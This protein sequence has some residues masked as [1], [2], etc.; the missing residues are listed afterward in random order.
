MATAR[1]A[2]RRVSEA[3]ADAE[4]AAR[5]Q[6]W[7]SVLEERGETLG[8]TFD[9]VGDADADAGAAAGSSESAAGSSSGW[10]GGAAGGSSGEGSATV[11]EE[12]GNFDT[13][14]VCDGGGLLV[15]CEACPQAYHAACLGEEAPP[16]EEEEGQAWFCPPCKAQLG[17]A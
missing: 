11:V 1:D 2:R 12:D 8:Y 6:H 10:V 4:A 17:M 5:A 3:T 7:V 16:E 13:C 9:D 15:C 14:A